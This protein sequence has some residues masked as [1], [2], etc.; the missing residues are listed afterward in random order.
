MVIKGYHKKYIVF[1]SLVLIVFVLIYFGLILYLERPRK[2]DIVFITIALLL[3]VPILL[4]H[5]GFESRKYIVDGVGICTVWFG[6]V[7][8][9]NKWEDYHL[10]KIETIKSF[11]AADFEEEAIVFS[12]IDLKMR[13]MYTNNTYKKVIELGWVHNHPYNVVTILLK[14]LHEDQLEEI[15]SY[16]PEKF[17]T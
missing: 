7:Q 14:D 16:V 1:Y 2:S 11:F 8:V 5:I 17:K 9:V 13:D 15:W 3:N 12:K 4:Y 6:I 10:V